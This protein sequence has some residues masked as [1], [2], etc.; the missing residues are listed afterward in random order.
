M[1][2]RV[3]AAGHAYEIA[4]QRFWCAGKFGAGVVELGNAYCLDLSLF[5][6]DRGYCGIFT[7]PD[8][9]IAAA[10]GQFSGN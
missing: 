9:G 10:A 1:K 8:A 4:F 2:G 6:F 5:V 3:P 7:Y